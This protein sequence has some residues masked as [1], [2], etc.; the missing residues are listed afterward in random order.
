MMPPLVWARR[1]KESESLFLQCRGLRYHVRSWGNPLAPKVFMLH[2]WMDVSAS[3]QFVV[4]EMRFDWHVLAPDWRGFGL[5]DWSQADSYWYPDYLADLDALIS[6][7]Q[8]DKPINLVGHSMGGNIACLYAG[9]RPERIARLVNLEGLGMSDS[10]PADAP[11]KYAHWLDELNR[12]QRLRSYASYDDL[13]QRL[14]DSNQR[15]SSGR[16]QFLA[17]HWGMTSKDGSI[18]LRGDPVHKRV[19]P[20]LYR[21]AEVAACLRQIS[22]P[23]L[24]VEGELTEMFK[25]F[26]LSREE[27][28]A[29]RREIPNCIATTINGAG[30]MMHHDQPEIVAQV[31]DDFLH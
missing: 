10:N 29:R 2:G 7:L 22:A 21:G 5:T 31:I 3:F 4:D 18:A 8:P 19:N 9:I 28:D 14:Q 17:R 20:V 13:A 11:K 16:G 27:I 15:L 12:P 6:A 30:H 25:K 26:R 23:V 1:M 24:W